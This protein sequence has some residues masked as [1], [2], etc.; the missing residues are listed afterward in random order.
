MLVGGGES[1][2]EIRNKVK[3]LKMEK[4]VFFVGTK[5]NVNQYMWAMDI[6]I[7]PSLFEG[8]G[9]GLIEAQATGLPCFTSED[10][11]PKE[12]NVSNHVIYISLK[13]TAKEWAN[14]IL[15]SNLQRFDESKIIKE[16]GYDILDTAKRLEEFYINS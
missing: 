11:V 12:A 13:K 2:K 4:E 3:E 6:F 8:L 7:F 10:V 5:S 14:I 9:L 15:N 1:E 16:K